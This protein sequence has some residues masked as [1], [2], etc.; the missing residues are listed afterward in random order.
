MKKQILLLLMLLFCFSYSGKANEATL[1]CDLTISTTDNSMTIENLEATHI[2]LKLFN[3]DFSINYICNDNCDSPTTVINDLQEGTTYFLSVNLYDE[4][5]SLICQES[6]YVDID[7]GSPPCTDDDNDGICA[8]DDCDDSDATLPATPGTSCDDGDSNTENDMIQSDGCTCSGTPMSTGCD[9]NWS[10]TNN[11]ITITGL[12]AP[13][14][15]FKLHNPNWSINTQCFDNC[16]DPFTISGL[17]T[18]ATY[19][20]NYNLYDENW[21]S[22]CEELV[23][24]PITGPIG[25]TPDL[26]IAN[27]QNDF[28]AN[29]G[30]SVNYSFDLENIGNEAAS[31]DYAIRVYL[32]DDNALDDNDTEV[33]QLTAQNTAIGST[34]LSGSFDT[35]DLPEGNYFLIANADDENDIS[36][37]NESNNNAFTN[38][39]ILPAPGDPCGFMKNYN[40]EPGQS[41]DIF[42]VQE[43][44]DQYVVTAQSASFLQGEKREVIFT[45]DKSGG[46]LST[47]DESFG[48]MPDA[49]QVSLELTDEFEIVLTKTSFGNA[50]WETTIVFDLPIGEEIIGTNANTNV[51][52][53]EGGYL[54]VTNLVTSTDGGSTFDFTLATVKLDEEGNELQRN[55]EEDP[56]GD[57]FS[58]SNPFE[59]ENGTVFNYRDGINL[60]FVK[61]DENGVF[62][63]KTNHTGDLPSNRLEQL[64]LSPDRKFVYAA[65]RNNQR[66]F[67]D[68]VDTNTGDKVYKLGLGIEFT[69]HPF[70]GGTEDLSGFLLEADGSVVTGVYNNNDNVFEYGKLDAEGNVIWD[71]VIDLNYPLSPLARTSDNGYYWFGGEQVSNPQLPSPTVVTALKTTATGGIE[72][73]CGGSVPS[74]ELGCDISYSLDGSNITFTGEG[75]N[76]A[77]TIIKVFGPSWNTL[78][79]CFDDCGS[80]I[81]LS[82]LVAGTYRIRVNLYDAD[83]SETCNLFEEFIITGANL[84]GADTAYKPWESTPDLES[85][86]ALYPNPTANEAFL[87]LSIFAGESATVTIYNKLGQAE[88]QIQISEILNEPIQ[89]ITR[90]LKA[91]MY[92]VTI[93]VE[94]QKLITK[95]L[96]VTKL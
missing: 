1:S 69:T 94:N 36:E 84:Q 64:G 35:P 43:Q 33:V 7:G 52:E 89:L 78:A 20:L 51:F 49:E 66:I 81:D 31:G 63:W 46:L 16:T 74:V 6:M 22:I 73:S 53:V 45:T 26:T 32:S 34:Y 54:V 93:R 42:S 60:A 19:H 25:G 57:F 3:P 44:T 90:D 88:N 58:L 17:T 65:N 18:G 30:A 71:Q 10:T 59:V 77:H 11:S 50:E 4:N 37:S 96:I 82:G 8:A 21:Q 80:S 48:P 29:V 12:T 40:F 5:W 68:K 55:L 92:M 95:K 70:M 23:S 27:L 24:V 62:E 72:P 61:F 79:N 9:V 14:V 28:S 38:F 13:H 85:A 2:I 39:E 41:I 47:T 56:F 67:L 86:L 83:W 75:F 91:G 76:A 87:D 15:I